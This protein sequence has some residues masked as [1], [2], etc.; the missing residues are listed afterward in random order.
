[1]VMKHCEITQHN[2][3]LTMD[4]EPPPKA[5][6]DHLADCAAC[7]AFQQS[8][9]VMAE[10]IQRLDEPPAAVDQAILTYARR[11]SKTAAVR[12]LGFPRI[13][14]YAAAASLVA[15]MSLSGWQA[16][17]RDASTG[18]GGQTPGAVASSDS[19]AWDN[20]N[21]TTAL[22]EMVATAD[23]ADKEE[24]AQVDTLFAD[25]SNEAMAGEIEKQLADIQADLYVAS[26]TFDKGY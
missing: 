16:F 6:T 5:S 22:G 1:M 12:W 2:L 20:D 15:L 7:Q 13:L 11:R 9:N 23:S 17:H 4:G 14:Q 18:S 25:E 19:K 3:L 8:L 10:G 24:S 21:L 26:L